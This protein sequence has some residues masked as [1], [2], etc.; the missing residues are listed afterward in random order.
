MQFLSA[1]H[2]ENIQLERV[3]RSHI[4]LIPKKPDAKTVEA[5]RPICLQNCSVKILSKVLTT[6]LQLQINKL[7][8]LDQTGFIRGRS[9]T[10]NFEFCICNGTGAMQP[11]EKDSNTGNQT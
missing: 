4:V 10:E 1:F 9:I 2:E 7:V 6:R 11:Q 5:Y 8:D 3:N